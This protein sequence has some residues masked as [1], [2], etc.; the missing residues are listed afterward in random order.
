PSTEI[1]KRSLAVHFRRHFV[2][3][4][5]VLAPVWLT[6]YIVLLAVRL[7]GGQLS[8][9][10]RRL[11][12]TLLGHGRY[13]GLVTTAA[14]V[15]AFLVTVILITI[16]G[17]AVSRVMGR[18]MLDVFD[19]ILRRIPFVREV[20][21]GIR[22]VADVLFGD[23]SS[24]QRVVAVRFP[25]EQAWSLGFVT[26][27]HTWNVPENSDQ[28]HTVIF[29]PTTPNVTTGFLLLCKSHDFV[30][31]SLSVDQAMK[32]LISVGTLS[33]ERVQNLAASPPGEISEQ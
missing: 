12:E 22:K 33:P 10:M 16:V 28:A 30:P 5:V 1:P 17:F 2:T 31:L 11:A 3:G 32:V 9:L 18:R 24:F 8:P 7:V 25:T 20:Y 6:V 15:V 29:V 14:D 19:T 27:E 23:K 21:G 4:L 26:S 13:A